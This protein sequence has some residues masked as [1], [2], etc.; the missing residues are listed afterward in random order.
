MLYA[1]V[2]IVHL[3]ACLMLIAAILLQ[4]GRGGGLSETF[5][6]DSQKTLFGA[7]A[8]VFLTRAT[9]TA[10]CLFLVTSLLLGVLT[11][12]RGKSIIDFE[13]ST[14]PEAQ[15]QTQRQNQTE[16]DIP[17]IPPPVPIDQE[18]VQ[19]KA[20]E[21]VEPQPQPIPIDEPGGPSMD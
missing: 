18:S 10:A 16:A 3:T 9:V 13:G 8:N 2:I 19:E 1:F 5:G 21:T 12:R 20:Q 15:R 17:Y 7:K 14:D 6:S 4:A 11:S